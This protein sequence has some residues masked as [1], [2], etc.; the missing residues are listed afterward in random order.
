MT[1]GERWTAVNGRPVGFDYLRIS[2]AFAVAIWHSYQ[3][4]YGTDAVVELY[5][6]TAFGYIIQII[7]PM[8]F[9]LSGFL[10]AG[11]MYRN[12]N[13][14][15]FLTLR[16]IR[17]FPALVVEVVLVAFI[18]GPVVTTFKLESYFRNREF[19]IYLCNVVGYIHFRL[20]GVFLTNPLPE[21]IN[22]QLWTVPFELECYILIALIFLLGFFRSKWRV[23]PIFSLA[24]IGLVLWNVTH[25]QSPDVAVGWSGRMLVLSFLAGVVIY[26]FKDAIPRRSDLAV[27]SF[28]L[29]V[30]APRLVPDSIYLMPLFAAYFTIYVGMFNPRRT[31]IV[32]SGDYSYGVY[33]YSNPIEQTVQFALPNIPW[34]ANA[35]CAL[36]ITVAFALFSWWFVEKPF[37][38]VRKYL[39]AATSVNAKKAISGEVR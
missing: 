26:A 27:V 37:M 12:S 1:V 13:L 34:F 10:V 7:L 3:V 4:A 23:L 19:F 17:I 18:L 32:N 9:S 20:P 6:R 31:I 5:D 16:A 11:S 35:A 30:L 14:R 38:K 28:T 33:L 21:I 22:S 39:H 29:I 2:L 24:T 8:F 15:I 25:H 36:P